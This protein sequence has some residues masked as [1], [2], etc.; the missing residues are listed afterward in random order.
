MKAKYGP[1]RGFWS[2]AINDLPILLG[3]SSVSYRTI[4]VKSD[5][6]IWH[7]RVVP[8]WLFAIVALIFALVILGHSPDFVFIP[9]LTKEI[10]THLNCTNANWSI[11]FENEIWVD[12]FGYEL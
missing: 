12:W 2:H 6:N 11:L 1:W 4:F 9:K 8:D 10:Y 7:N 5:C 3:R